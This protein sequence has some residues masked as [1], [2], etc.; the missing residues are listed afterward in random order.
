MYDSIVFHPYIRKFLARVLKGILNKSA[1][2]RLGSA[3]IK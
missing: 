3:R 2:N 1:V